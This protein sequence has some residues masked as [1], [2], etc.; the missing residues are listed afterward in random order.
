MG[1]G[2]GMGPCVRAATMLVMWALEI[3]TQVE[4]G[5]KLCFHGLRAHLE[6]AHNLSA[7]RQRG[8]AEALAETL[9]VVLPRLDVVQNIGE[10]RRP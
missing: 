6:E 4:L 9:T 10:L 8:C 7:F 3:L 5:L 1:M 2:M